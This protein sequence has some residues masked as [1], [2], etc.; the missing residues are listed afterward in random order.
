M[1]WGQY[2]PQITQTFLWENLKNF[3]KNVYKNVYKH[4]YNFH[5][6]IKFDL[7]YSKTTIKFVTTVYKNKEHLLLKTVYCKPKY[8]RNFL[9]NTS[10]HIRSVIK[11]ITYM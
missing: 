1:Q 6:K 7:E 11:S 3:Y 5:P 4:F 2:V 8:H 9:H 10:A